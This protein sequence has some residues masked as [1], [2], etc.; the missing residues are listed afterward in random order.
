MTYTHTIESQSNATWSWF[1]DWL[2]VPCDD[3]FDTCA[4]IPDW[5]GKVY[6]FETLLPTQ[7]ELPDNHPSRRTSESCESQDL[8]QHTIVR[9]KRSKALDQSSVKVIRWVSQSWGIV[10]TRTKSFMVFWVIRLHWDERRQAYI[11]RWGRE[12]YYFGD[13]KDRLSASYGLVGM[14]CLYLL[15]P[16]YLVDYSVQILR[17]F[18]FLSFDHWLE[19][20]LWRSHSPHRSI[21]KTPK[22][23]N[24]KEVW[25]TSAKWSRGRTRDEERLL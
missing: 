13:H 16:F 7:N 9:T 6:R 10:A 19:W 20:D 18:V 23:A 24:S 21:R 25:V 3:E 17:W 11:R 14:T 22:A 5:D 12:I 4:G 2:T 8:T 1:C 15:A